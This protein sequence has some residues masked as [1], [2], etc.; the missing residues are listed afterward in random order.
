MLEI[1]LLNSWSGMFGHMNMHCY[2]NPAKASVQTEVFKKESRHHVLV[3]RTSG[4]HEKS[5]FLIPDN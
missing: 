4:S 3:Q 1:L 5:S 2:I